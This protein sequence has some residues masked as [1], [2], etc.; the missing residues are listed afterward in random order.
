MRQRVKKTVSVLLLIVTLISLLPTYSIAI[1]GGGNTG[2]GYR[3]TTGGKGDWGQL[4]EGYR[5]VVVDRDFNEVSN[6]VDIVFSD[7]FDTMTGSNY[8]YKNTRASKT[9]LSTEIPEHGYKYRTVDDLFKTPEFLGENKPYPP[10]WYKSGES[11]ARGW[12]EE[13]RQ[14][15]IEDATSL[16]SYIPPATGGGGGEGGG[17]QN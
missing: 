15:F 17:T 13:F 11:T 16:G 4:K 9:G 7:P 2:G 8:W 3:G 6:V 14:W 1:E 10:V 5:F 12:G